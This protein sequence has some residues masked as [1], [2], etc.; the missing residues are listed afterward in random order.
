[1]ITNNVGRPFDVGICPRVQK[2]LD[3]LQAWQIAL[4]VV[5]LEGIPHEELED[6]EE[7]AKK[8]SL[9]QQAQAG[10]TA[11]I[12]QNQSAVRKKRRGLPLTRE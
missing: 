5:Q 4:L 7:P 12:V 9:S 11:M 3:E 8:A 1:M 10:G 2:L 6:R